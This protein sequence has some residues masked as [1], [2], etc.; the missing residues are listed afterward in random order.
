MITA[1]IPCR[2][3]SER[4]AKKNTKLFAGKEGGLLAIKLE[5]LLKVK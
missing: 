5:Q 3:G 1:F 4:I 2:A